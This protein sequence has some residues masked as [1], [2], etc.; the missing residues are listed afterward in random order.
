MILPTE[1]IIHIDED[2]NVIGLCHLC[3]KPRSGRITAT[4]GKDGRLNKLYELIC[5]Y[6]GM[7]Q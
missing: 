3:H 2:I 6:C 5:E 1:L 7:E 4:V